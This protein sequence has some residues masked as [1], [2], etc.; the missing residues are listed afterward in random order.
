MSVE[1]AGSSAGARREPH[2]RASALGLSGR[3]VLLDSSLGLWAFL[4]KHND[5]IIVEGLYCSCY[6]FLKRVKERRCVHLEALDLAKKT[7]RYRRLSYS[8]V[9]DVASIVWECLTLSHSPRLR[10]LVYGER[11]V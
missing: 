2:S 11:G 6:E 7:G 4:G 3:F 9:E 1:D 5:Y 10:S 8:R